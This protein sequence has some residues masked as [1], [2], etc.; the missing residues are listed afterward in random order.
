MKISLPA[1]T[2]LIFSLVAVLL[3][4]S[5]PVGAE[6]VRTGGGGG[7]PFD[8]AILDAARTCG[9]GSESGPSPLC[10]AHLEFAYRES[11]VACGRIF[12][13]QPEARRMCRAPGRVD[14]LESGF[15]CNCSGAQSR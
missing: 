7:R 11:G 2:N 9:A 4:S 5:G 1:I 12:A 13:A 15:L 3:L 10:F 14:R 6:G 8:M